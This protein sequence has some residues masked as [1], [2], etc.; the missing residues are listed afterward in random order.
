M[1]RK[2]NCNVLILFLA[3]TT[4]AFGQQTQ[5][6][7]HI[8]EVD[9]SLGSI[10]ELEQEKRFVRLDFELLKSRFAKDRL[11]LV[12]LISLEH[13]DPRFHQR[14]KALELLL[15]RLKS[16]EENLQVR[17]AMLAAVILL[18]DASH[19]ALLWSIVTADSPFRSSLERKLVQWKSPVALQD[20]RHRLD[21]PTAKPTELATALEGLMAVGNADDQLA[22]QSVIRASHSSVANKYLAACALGTLVTEGLNEF[23]QQ[24]LDSNLD[25]R[26]L[27][28]AQLIRLHSGASTEKQMRLILRDGP[29]SAQL[30]AYRFMTENS[31]DASREFVKQMTSHSDPSL[32]TLAIR[33]LHRFNDDESLQI[34]GALLNDRN[35]YI[36]K[37]VAKHLIEKASQ[38]LR[39]RVDECVVSHLESAEWTGIEK[40][41][42]VSVALQ[43]RSRCKEFLRLLEHPRPEVNLIAGWALMEIG[44]QEEILARMLDHAEK[45]TAEL[46]SSEIVS[47]ISHTDRIRLSYLHEAFG[48]N[49]YEP[50]NQM[51]LKYVPKLGHQFGNISRASAIWSLGKLNKGKRNDALRASLHDRISDLSPIN[52]EDN[53]VRFTCHLALG[54]MANPDSSAVNKRFRENLPSPVAYAADWALMKIDQASAAKPTE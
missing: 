32:R 38:G 1:L 26:H 13:N 8:W 20:W 54:E 7:Q 27:L 36:R 29:A 43:D 44:D 33:F 21:D 22:L 23:A 4:L 18:S 45:M 34:Q 25:Q 24:V 2:A 37:L 39:A 41:I 10:W 31:P 48:K 15:D 14:K 47:L 3:T 12:Q 16:G 17:Q 46:K 50:A 52:P 42:F 40:A 5:S 28:A 51:L 6:L 9:P 49:R 19:A 11:E 35:P 53:L 30:V